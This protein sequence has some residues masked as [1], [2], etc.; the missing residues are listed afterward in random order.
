VLAAAVL[1]AA[2]VGEEAVKETV[3]P[4]LPVAN[5][6][7]WAVISFFGLWMLL[8]YVFLP[9]VVRTIDD[10][11]GKLREA[12]AAAD[13]ATSGAD[14]A[15]SAYNARVNEA[16]GEASAILAAARDDAERYRAQRVAEVNAEIATLREQ[17]SAEV[18]A[19]KDAAREQLRSQLAGI[20]VNAASRVVQRDL[21]LEAQLQ[22]IEN[23]V[24]R[25]NEGGA[26]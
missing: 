10:R 12:R 19:A 20:V 13:S 1:L 3:N 26:A 9:P 2:E 5:E 4:I 24:N 21:P 15:V 25:A 23:Y 18:A 7:V 8:R 17:A 11:D 16:R 6:I 14:D 22:V